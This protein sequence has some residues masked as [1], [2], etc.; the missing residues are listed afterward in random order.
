MDFETGE[1]YQ[2]DELP[3]NELNHSGNLEWVGDDTLVLV[4]DGKQVEFKFSKVQCKD[5]KYITEDGDLVEEEP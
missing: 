3:D 2:I 4:H 1:H 5:I